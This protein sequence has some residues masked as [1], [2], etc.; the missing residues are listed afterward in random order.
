MTVT[1]YTVL[2]EQEWVSVVD[3]FIPVPGPPGAGL[4]ILGELADPADLPDT[5]SPGDAYIIDGDLWVWAD[6]AWLDVGNVQGPPG[7]TGATGPEGPEGIPGPPGAAG[8]PGAGGEIGA[9]GPQG[10]V[11]PAGVDGVDGVDGAA[12]ARRRHRR[13]RSA[14]HPRR[15]RGGRPGRVELPR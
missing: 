7:A 2:E 11:G 14:R 12:G 10:L 4:N 5:G 15:N 6:D 8:P 9:T 3:G 13:P 1:E